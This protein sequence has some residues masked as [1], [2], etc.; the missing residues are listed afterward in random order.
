MNHVQKKLPLAAICLL[1]AC[2]LPP[3]AADEWSPMGTGNMPMAPMSP[4]PPTA[5]EQPY[6]S[7]APQ[8]PEQSSRPPSWPSSPPA[9][10]S[11]WVPPDQRQGNPSSPAPQPLGEKVL[12]DGAVIAGRVGTEVILM[13]DVERAINQ[14]IEKNKDKLSAADIEAQRPYLAKPALRGCIESKLIYL[15]AKRT[16]P[17]EGWTDVN[18]KLAKE[19]ENNELEKM[20]KQSGVATRQELDQKLRALGSSVERE[21]KAFCERTLAQL[22]VRQ[23]IKRDEEITYDQMV[24][25]Y[26]QH[27][28]E[29]TTP[30]RAKWE[31][32]M[33]RFD[34][35]PNKAA[36][37]DAIARLGNQVLGG[38]P[39][40]EVAKAASDGP[41]AA[42]GGQRRWT[43]KG[44]LV[45]GELD[46][47]LF[48]LPVGRLSPIIEGPTGFHI[49]R[50]L[51]REDVR[52]AP[53][54]EAQVDIREKIVHQRTE[55][56]FREYMAKLE[57]RIPIWTIF[58]D[59]KGQELLS[60][61]PGSTA[62][63]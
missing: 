32:L 10:S 59:G 48:E 30:A 5:T 61:R 38:A 25:Y 20:M 16:I 58:D 34:K 49:I 60:K 6:H 27:Q 35:H 63:K 19:F 3:V 22:W 50:V 57:A 4:A 41:S 17:A 46:R 11:P 18:E 39:L 62:V 12:C 24:T 8:R 31:E 23:Q 55:K 51:E 26:H 2:L 47:A 54:L 45:C 15:D 56:Q 9:D 52:V 7:S 29:F 13:S 37:Y 42:E 33:V 53:F 36:A 14:L 40:A 1:A 28:D 21:K 44:S 43:T